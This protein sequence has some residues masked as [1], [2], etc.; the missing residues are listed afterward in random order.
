MDRVAEG[1]LVEDDAEDRGDRQ[2]DELAPPQPE[3]LP[4]PPDDCRQRDAGNRPA[5]CHVG[6]RIELIYRHGRFTHQLGTVGVALK[7]IRLFQ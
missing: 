7:Q 3:G 1:D 4:A 5:K 6:E 2:H